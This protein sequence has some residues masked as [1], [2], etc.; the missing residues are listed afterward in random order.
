MT[1]RDWR[2]ALSHP[3]DEHVTQRLR[4]WSYRGCPLGSDSFISKIETRFGMRLRPQVRER[5]RKNQ[6]SGNRPD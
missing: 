1:G 3:Q 2:E 4:T 5:P 6:E